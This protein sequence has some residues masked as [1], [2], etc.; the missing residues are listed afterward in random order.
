MLCDSALPELISDLEVN[1]TRLL[2]T[3]HCPPPPEITTTITTST[4]AEKNIDQLQ[5]LDTNN[6]NSNVIEINAPPL[7]IPTLINASTNTQYVIENLDISGDKSDNILPEIQNLDVHLD[8]EPQQSSGLLPK[9]VILHHAMSEDE[10]NP[11]KHVRT[12]D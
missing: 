9:T 1:N 11:T 10:D 12:V 6:N 2:G 3:A 4:L 7:M 8:Q 5:I